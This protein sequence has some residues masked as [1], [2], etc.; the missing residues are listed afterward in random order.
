ML[1]ILISN[2]TSFLT[3]YSTGRW[4]K[5]P[6]R[7]EKSKILTKNYNKFIND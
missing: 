2:Y 7:S 5:N 1:V 4:K 6:S 3:V